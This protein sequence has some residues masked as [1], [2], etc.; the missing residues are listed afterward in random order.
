MCGGVAGCTSLTCAHGGVAGSTP[1]T[2]VHGGVTGSTIV[3]NGSPTLLSVAY[4]FKGQT[5]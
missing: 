5:C 2:C 1:L 3:S 4:T